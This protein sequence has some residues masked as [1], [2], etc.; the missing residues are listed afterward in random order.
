MILYN[1]EEDKIALHIY[2]RNNMK[3]LMGYHREGLNIQGSL[4]FTHKHTHQKKKKSMVIEVAIYLHL[5]VL[6]GN[7][8]EGYSQ[9]LTTSYDIH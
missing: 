1:K 4:T 3:T 5:E 2:Y 7:I 6:G 8:T 9:E